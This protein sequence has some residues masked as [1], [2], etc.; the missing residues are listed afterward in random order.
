MFWEKTVIRTNFCTNCSDIIVLRTHNCVMY[1]IRSWILYYTPNIYIFLLAPVSKV[2]NSSFDQYSLRI[3][4][5][6]LVFM[7]T[8]SD[9]AACDC[10]TVGTLSKVAECTQVQK[11]F[12]LTNNLRTQRALLTDFCVCIRA[13]ASV[14]VN[15]T[16]AAG[17]VPYAK[18]DTTISNLQT[19]LGAKVRNQP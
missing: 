7:C 12:H 5:S 11:Y 6:F 9:F 16:C 15:P 3:T 17:P 1:Q 2:T 4:W 10:D 8:L 13:P 18:T 19:T 14:T